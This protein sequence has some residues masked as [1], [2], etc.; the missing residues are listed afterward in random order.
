ME[1]NHAMA[2]R[3][4]VAELGLPKRTLRRRISE[5]LLV[6]VNPWVVA[7]PGLTLDIKARTRAAVLARPTIIPTGP[8]AAA[9]L[10]AGPWDRCDLGDEPWFV[11]PAGRRSLGRTVSHPGVRVVR[12][13]DLRVSHPGDAAV[14]LIRLWPPAD[15]LAVAQRSLILGMLTLPGLIAAHSSLTRLAG[16]A[17]LRAVIHELSEG[18]VSEGERRLVELL[19]ESGVT[20]WIANHGVRVGRRRYVVDVAFPSASVAVE[21]DGHAYHSDVRAFQ[22]DRTRQNDLV[23]AGWTVLRFTWT[24]ITQHPEDV[25]AVITSTLA[26][27]RGA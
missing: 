14:D 16:A 7:L 12:V 21:V 23:R 26:G 27:K 2:T 22:N 17:Q 6:P 24:D 9:F 13:G 10:G 5:G 18:T 3:N 8:A 20:G 1:A 15:A 19:R 4:A 11:M 25:L